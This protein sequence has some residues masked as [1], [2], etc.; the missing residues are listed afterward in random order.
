MKLTTTK[1][2]PV[3]KLREHPQNK[4]FFSDMTGAQWQD[5]LED[6]KRNGITSPLT[7]N[8]NGVVI[9][10]HQ[11]LRAA[12]ELSIESVPCN[13]YVY[14]DDEEELDDLIRD[15]VLRRDLDPYNKFVLTARLLRRNQEVSRQGARTDLEDDDVTSGPGVQKLPPKDKTMEEAGVG[16]RTV[17]AASKF[18]ALSEDDK[19]KIKAWAIEK[20]K[21][22]TQKELTKKVNEISQLRAE[23]GKNERAVES[24]QKQ[25]DEF[26][27]TKDEHQKLKNDIK[28][29]MNQRG[30]LTRDWDNMQRIISTCK[31]MRGRFEREMSFL[32]H[33]KISED[34]LHIITPQL[35]LFLET[36]NK[37]GG[38]VI[39]NFGIDMGATNE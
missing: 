29:L 7:T 31:D 14:E 32:A 35:K 27:R 24:L 28:R 18:N 17:N 39:K 30:S 12:K 15:N 36:L 38:A 20:G 37:W 4:E 19:D 10:G 33:T 11:R 21:A 16:A 5:F 6:V 2:V 8:Q 25:L 26:E 23:L 1:N 22:L 13:I 9:K 34:N 3:E